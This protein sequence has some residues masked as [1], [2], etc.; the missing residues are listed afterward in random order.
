MADL[1]PAQA[2]PYFAHPT[3]RRGARLPD[4]QA[5][6][7]FCVYRVLDGVCGAF[8]QAIWPG[9]WVGH[10]GVLPTAWGHVDGPAGQIL[11]DFAAEVGA[12]RILAVFPERNRA[13]AAMC[14]RLGFETDGRLPLA[15][16]VLIMGWTPCL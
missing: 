9:A 12:E 6:P 7:D 5:L 15:E 13:V 4:G 10:I 8:H 1:T 2:A 3:Q 11:R 14:R 16:P